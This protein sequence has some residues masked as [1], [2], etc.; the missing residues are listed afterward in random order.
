MAVLLLNVSKLFGVAGIIAVAANTF[1]LIRFRRKRMTPFENP[2][3]ESQELL[4]RFP[5]DRDVDDDGFF[6]A[7]ATNSSLLEKD[8]WPMFPVKSEDVTSKEVDDSDHKEGMETGSQDG[9]QLNLFESETDL[10]DKITGEQKLGEDTE[11]KDKNL[12]ENS[13]N[14]STVHIDETSE[15]SKKEEGCSQHRDCHDSSL[16]EWELLSMEQTAD[17]EQKSHEQI[18]GFPSL[19]DHSESEVDNMDLGDGK[20]LYKMSD[21]HVELHGS[22][23]GKADKLLD[24]TL[25]GL[26][27][28]FENLKKE[29][30]EAVPQAN[31][32]CLEEN[33]SFWYNPDEELH[34][35]KETN[36]TVLRMGIDWSRIMPKEPLDGVEEAINQEALDQYRLFTERVHTHGLRVMLTLFHSSL[37]AWA[38]AYGGWQNDK[39]IDYFIEYTRVVVEKLCD[40]VDFWITFNE[41]NVFALTEYC[42][43]GQTNLFQAAATVLSRR[44]FRNVINR[45]ATAHIKAYDI[46]HD[47]R[48]KSSRK[49]DVGIAHRASFM[50]PY[51]LFD[52][53]TVKFSNWMTNCTYVD[54]VCKKLDFLGI[55]YYGQEF[56]SSF[57]LKLV[58][59]EEY[60]EAGKGIY[61]DGL[62]RELLELHNRYK[63]FNVPFIVTENGVADATD[64]LRR[65][66]ILEHL[67]AVKAAMNKGVPVKGYCYCALSD[68]WERANEHSLQFGLASIDCERNPKLVQRPSYYL[69]SEVAKSGSITKEQRDKAWAQ[70]QNAVMQENIHVIYLGI[71]D[72]STTSLGAVEKR[73]VRSFVKKD[74]RFG[75]YKPDGLRDPLSCTIRYLWKLPSMAFERH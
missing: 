47:I 15:N 33:P 73:V 30:K 51:G 21:Q 69:L 5:I 8:A 18:F 68:N 55:N 38:S 48:Q 67:L 41:P 57:G 50:Q 70:L 75:H 34:M 45:M 32:H 13:R 25:E 39:T 44:V 9:S 40:L 54:I 26:I 35:A 61:P 71:G 27:K 4:A 17:K 56:V 59:N 53:S 36:A 66:Y 24:P 2:I 14:V 28:G 63:K 6:F 31:V 11:N 58:D 49:L 7:I 19:A 29:H 46:I 72:Q 62:Y 64:Y 52:M 74:W 1:A 42:T 12:C 22:A 20:E 3:D 65:P 60:S 10:K 16:D 37:P 43:G 23:A